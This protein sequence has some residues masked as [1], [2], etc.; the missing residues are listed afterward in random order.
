MEYLKK[1]FVYYERYKIITLSCVVTFSFILGF[2]ILG[3]F[4]TSDVY[5]WYQIQSE[6]NEIISRLVD[7][8]GLIADKLIASTIPLFMVW[9]VVLVTYR[10]D[11]T[12][13]SMINE[14]SKYLALFTGTTAF[15]VLSFGSVLIGICSYGL[16]IY[17]YNHGFLIAIT[18]STMLVV[19][20][21]IIRKATKPELVDNVVLN[22]LS[23]FMLFV[24]ICLM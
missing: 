8:Q 21:F 1:I 14:N 10:L 16:K 3:P 12:K 17:G 15:I 18:F 4:I 2:F 5:K 19:C 22:K 20:G 11:K 7:V 23:G 9:I 24:C 6:G 13:I